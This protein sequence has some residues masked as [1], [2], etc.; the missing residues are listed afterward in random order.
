MDYEKVCISCFKWFDFIKVF[1]FEEVS[2]PKN[3]QMDFK[4]KYEVCN[5]N[6]VVREVDS[7]TVL[8][9]STH[10]SN[11]WQLVSARH[12][13]DSITSLEA[14]PQIY[15][16]DFLLFAKIEVLIFIKQR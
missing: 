16:N 1:A 14:V 2:I 13:G 15:A 7:S 5:K 10:K 6:E 11:E 4:F 12:S 8:Q 3:I 9:M